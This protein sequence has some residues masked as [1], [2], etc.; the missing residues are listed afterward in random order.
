MPAILAWQAIQRHIDCQK[1][2][3]VSG[4]VANRIECEALI[5]M[6]PPAIALGASSAREARR[7][8]LDRRLHFPQ[9]ET[10]GRLVNLHC[11]GHEMG[12]WLPVLDEGRQLGDQATGQVVSV[13]A[14][15]H[16][17]QMTLAK[18]KRP[19]PHPE[20]ALARQH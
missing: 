20:R 13:S 6:L 4:P 3:G 11:G 12:S 1:H 17:R 7:Q 15:W 10:V 19:A 14:H 8:R 18:E 5:L 16:S 2:N 9:I